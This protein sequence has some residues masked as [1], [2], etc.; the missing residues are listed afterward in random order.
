MMALTLGVMTQR[1]TSPH[2]YAGCRARTRKFDVPIHP[3]RAGRR[4]PGPQCLRLTPRCVEPPGS[5][6]PLNQ[7]A[8]ETRGTPNP[9]AAL[10]NTIAIEAGETFEPPGSCRS[11]AASLYPD[12][13]L[14]TKCRPAEHEVFRMPTVRRP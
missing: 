6:H 9:Q 5:E 10:P 11:A 13:A 3:R 14:L 12:R 7:V 4:K 8:H 2:I 1:R